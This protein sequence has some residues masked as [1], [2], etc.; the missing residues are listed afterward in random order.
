MQ[1]EIDRSKHE[2]GEAESESHGEFVDGVAVV[3]YG[4]AKGNTSEGERR[5]EV[6]VIDN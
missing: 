5:R 6:T 3:L 1:G 4:T 2:R